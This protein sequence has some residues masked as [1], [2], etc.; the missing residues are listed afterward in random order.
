MG[1]II[2][3]ESA[4]ERECPMEKRK[5]KNNERWLRDHFGLIV[6]RFGG[7]YPYVFV[8]GGRVFP[9]RRGQKVSQVEKRIRE[10]YG[11]T[12]GMPVPRPRDFHSI[13][14]L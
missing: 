1:V 10:Q 11:E 14:F 2:L 3:S 6:D 8:A 5:K 4:A 12:L 9:V 7:R 13:L